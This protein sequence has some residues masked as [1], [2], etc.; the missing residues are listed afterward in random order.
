MVLPTALAD[1]K[2]LGSGT[3]PGTGPSQRE[4]FD[5]GSNRLP[6]RLSDCIGPRPEQHA[7]HLPDS[8]RFPSASVL[9]RLHGDPEMVSGLSVGNVPAPLVR[10]L[11]LDPLNEFCPVHGSPS[12]SA[13]LIRDDL[14][15]TST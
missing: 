1:A 10:Q 7:Y 6:L 15:G 11:T 9:Q 5:D 3:I 12:E 13:L 2:N 14:M 8:D 4:E